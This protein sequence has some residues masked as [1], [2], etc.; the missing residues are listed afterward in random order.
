MHTVLFGTPTQ[1][2]LTF[3]E[4]VDVFPKLFLK[5]IILEK[6]FE[7]EANRLH[8]HRDDGSREQISFCC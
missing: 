7:N 5:G 8:I 2:F 3:F 1:S 6:H 4:V